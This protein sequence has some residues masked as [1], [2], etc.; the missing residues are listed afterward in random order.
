MRRGYQHQWS[1]EEMEKK[2]QELLA[3]PNLREMC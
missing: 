2:R 1:V 3:H